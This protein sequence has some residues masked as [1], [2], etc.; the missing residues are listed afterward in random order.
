[1]ESATMQ[2]EKKK[3]E[4][5]IVGLQR[6]LSDT[7][8]MLKGTVSKVVAKA[9]K[10]G[11]GERETYLLTYKGEGNKTRTVY[12]SKEKVTE[13]KKMIANYRRKKQILEKIVELNI[14]LFKMKPDRVDRNDENP[15]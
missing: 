9:K 7:G 3:I 5:K 2:E 12:V 1:M 14:I 13:A 4:S 15:E 6:K 10:E 11:G 8:G